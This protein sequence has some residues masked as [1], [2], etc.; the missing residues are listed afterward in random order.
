[1]KTLFLGGLAA[2]VAPRIVGNMTEKLETEV[3]AELTDTQRLIP[4]L[5]EAE[6]VVGHVWRS[7]FPEAPRHHLAL[8]PNR[9]KMPPEAHTDGR[10]RC[11][12][13]IC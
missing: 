6:I 5:A 12:G 13:G 11:D 10:L 3:L 8:R 1:M 2:R 4:A 9:Q 7:D